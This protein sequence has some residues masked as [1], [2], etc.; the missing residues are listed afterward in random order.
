MT[1]VG[2]L[3]QSGGTAT[4]SSERENSLCSPSTNTFYIETNTFVNLE[5]YI[6]QFEQIQI[7][8]M[9]QSVGTTTLSLER[10]NSLCCVNTEPYWVTNYPIKSL[11]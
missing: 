10:E 5:K 11:F 8:D 6:V 2:F 1:C 7:D 9:L 3:L 4:L